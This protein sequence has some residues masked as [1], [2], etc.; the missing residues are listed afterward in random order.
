MKTAIIGS[1]MI[2]LCSAYYLN[3]QGFDV[4]IIDEGDGSDNCSFGNAGYFCP[5]HMIPLASPGIISQGLKWMTN[6]ESPF[7]IK[8]SLDIDLARW[9]WNFYRAATKSRV[10]KAVP[11][12]NQML[13]ESRTLIED[14]LS[15]TKIDP[16]FGSKGLLMYCKSQHI[17]DEE[18]EVAELAR[19]CGQDVDVL[20]SAQAEKL[21]PGFEID[22]VGAVHFK[23]DAWFTPNTFM[24]EF[25]KYLEAK[26]VVFKFNTQVTG[27]EKNG[28]KVSALLTSDA[29]IDADQF[30]VATGSWSAKFLNQLGVKILVQGGKG[31][32]FT[33]PNP[34]VMPETASILTEA[35]VAVTP[36]QGGL[37]FAGT[38]EVNGLDLS[39]NP[40]RIKGLQ[41]S[42][43]A[44]FPQFDE[45]S[46]EGLPVWA[47]LRPCS[48]DGLPYIGKTKKFDNL[49]VATGHAMLG[50]SLGPITGQLVA[51]LAQ[52]EKPHI[53][54]T[55]LKVERYS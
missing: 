34:P 3:Q 41:K 43:P 13:D 42:I 35:R 10:E 17:L 40:R 1:G 50:I 6:P 12:L 51:E 54:D 53:D 46:F 55:L 21:N 27:V 37:R 8:P 14:I 33:L 4:T 5:S 31:Y 7:Y 32:S 2:G 16:G 24:A 36:M 11:V 19:K 25:Q 52:E 26:G 49:I 28:S 29:K 18:A 9:G 48:P 22:T 39:I 15:E 23:N 47:G 20:T 30:V 44:Y 38:M 45:G